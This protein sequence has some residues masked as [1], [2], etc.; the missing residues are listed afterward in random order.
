MR[1][2]ELP[3]EAV[4]RWLAWNESR[5]DRVQPKSDQPL[6]PSRYPWTATL[7]AHW[8]EIR[9]EVDALVEDAILLPSVSDLVGSDQGNEGRWMNFVLHANGRWVEPNVARAPD[10]AALLRE[11]PDLLVAGYT[12]MGPRSHLP[13]HRGPNRGAL[14]YHL[15]VRVPG[16]PGAARIQVGERMHVWGDRAE[17]LFDDA[18]EHEAWN[19]ADADRYVLFVEFVWPLDGGV[20]ALNRITQRLFAF[21]GRGVAARATAL[22]RQLNG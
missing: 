10:T 9:A 19:D 17:L 4:G 11:V 3:N 7:R 15:G 8:D 22:D 12:V 21:T 1:I 20:G 5:I 18:V 13:R 16:S 14:R 6:D 2:A